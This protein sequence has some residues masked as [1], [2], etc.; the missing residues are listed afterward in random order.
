MKKNSESQASLD[1]TVNRYVKNV[2]GFATGKKGAMI[3][4]CLFFILIITLAFGFK[5]KVDLNA[6]VSDV[7]KKLAHIISKINGVESAEVMIT[8]ESTSKKVPA[9]SESISSSI[10]TLEG[11]DGKKSG[12]IASR[13]ISGNGGNALIIT[14]LEPEIRGVMVVARGAEDYMVKLNIINAVKTVLNIPGE[15]IEVLSMK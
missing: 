15:K 5:D 2:I 7:E 9:T 10:G 13:L 14:E 4:V 11:E 8:Y 6:D 1:E 12:D 3:L